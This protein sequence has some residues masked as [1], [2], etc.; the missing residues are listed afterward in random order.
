MILLAAKVF[1]VLLIA[2]IVIGV[3]LIIKAAFTE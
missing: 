2:A 1:A 3:G